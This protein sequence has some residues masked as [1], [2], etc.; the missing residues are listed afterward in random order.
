LVDFLVD[1][2]AE[3][4][5]GGNF[6]K[7]TFQRATT[8]IA[9]L[10]ERGPVKTVK[11]CQ[12]KWSSFR[13]L[14]RVIRAI[15]EVSGWVWDDKTGASITPHTASSWEDY[16]KHHPEAK[17]FRNKGWCHFANVSLLMPSSAVGANVFHPTGTHDEDSGTPAPSEP[18]STSQRDEPLV[19]DSDS[20]E[21]SQP[22]QSSALRK[23]ARE[24]ATPTRPSVKR[25]RA[26]NGAAALQDMSSSLT[27]VGNALSAALAPP[28]NAVDP[29]PRRRANAIAAVLRLETDWLD[30]SQLVAFIDF[31]RGDQIAGDVYLALT[32]PEVRKKWV[33][34]Q[35]AGLGVVVL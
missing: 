29:T 32:K 19:E 22:S 13:K 7:A 16:V 20:D 4:G 3:A 24:P 31:I 2:K 35:L 15:Q 25:P 9:P 27:Q 5:D 6:K 18:N 17:P 1:N 11:G 8:S 10:H 21:D 33:H 26:S 23:R 28:P 12:N 30:D 14:Y 34:T